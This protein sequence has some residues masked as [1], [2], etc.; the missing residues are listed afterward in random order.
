MFPAPVTSFTLRAPQRI[1]FG[2]GAAEQVPELAAEFGTRVLVARGR[3]VPWV[4]TCIARLCALGCDV[5]T[6]TARGEPDIPQIEAAL[7]EVRAWRPD[8]VLAIGGGAVIDLGKALAALAP[9]ACAPMTYLEVVGDGLPLDAEPLPFIAC[10]TT[11]GTGAEATRNAVVGVPAHN[12]KVSLRDDRM[13]AALAVVDPALT[14]ACPRTV[15]LAS[16]LDAITQVIEPF[17]SIRANPVTDALCRDAIPRGLTALTR[18]MQDEDRGARDDMAL[19]SLMGGIALSNAGLGAVHGFAGVIGG[20]FDAPHGAICGRLLGPVL[21]MNERVMANRGLP[22]DRYS[23]VR[24]WLGTGLGCTPD[25]AFQALE[26]WADAQ[27]LPPLSALIGPEANLTDIASEAH[28]SS[29]MKANSNPLETHELV[30]ILWET[31]HR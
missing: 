10:P 23:E 13:L 26:G 16:G 6:V 28:A 7:A 31:L 24:G 8:C 15:T 20:L 11:A 25:I 12:R 1:V 2:R 19:T 17:L 27:E 3:S 18:L 21:R 4:E 5:H 30:Q 14:D 22:T 29:S 9:A